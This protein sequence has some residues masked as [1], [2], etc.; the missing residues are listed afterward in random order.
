MQSR[1]CTWTRLFAIDL[2]PPGSMVGVDVGD[3]RLAIYNVTGEVYA[4]QNVCTH[5]FAI[6]SDGW[7]DGCTVECPLHGGRFD[8]TTGR[9]LGDPAEE[10]LRVYTVRVVDGE[11]E[12]LLPE[13]A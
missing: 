10:H 7:L 9:A 6:L 11:I 4:T 13:D 1:S 8:V 12:V 3:L 5:A 2:V